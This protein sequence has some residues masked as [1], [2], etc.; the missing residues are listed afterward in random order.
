MSF[1][2]F[3]CVYFLYQHA[4]VSSVKSLITIC[5]IRRYYTDYILSEKLKETKGV[6]RAAT[7]ITMMCSDIQLGDERCYHNCELDT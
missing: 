5:T 2:V 4:V 6:I 7:I 1:V 3:L